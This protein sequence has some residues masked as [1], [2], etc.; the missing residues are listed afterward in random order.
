MMSTLHKGVAKM[1]EFHSPELVEGTI[2]DLA[3]SIDRLNMDKQ[4]LEEQLQSLTLQISQLVGRMETWK[5]IHS[6]MIA[7]APPKRRKRGEGKQSILEILEVLPQGKYLTVGEIASTA[8]M[9]WSSVRNVIQQCEP[10]LESDGKGWR[11][12]SSPE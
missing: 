8:S 9:P 11:L 2:R 12:K 7:S 10:L 4:K 5:Q 6:K 3:N 1:S